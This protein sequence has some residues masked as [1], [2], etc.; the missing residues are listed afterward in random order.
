MPHGLLVTLSV[1]PY[2]PP[3]LAP[4]LF[5]APPPLGPSSLLP[6]PTG[7]AAGRQ[8]LAKPRMCL[9]G[10]AIHRLIDKHGQGAALETQANL[11]LFGWES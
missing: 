2:L 4:L 3:L 10:G 1:P 6:D 5:S 11:L 8:G 9:D 7:R